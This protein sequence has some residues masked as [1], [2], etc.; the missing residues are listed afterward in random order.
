MKSFRPEEMVLSKMEPNIHRASDELTGPSPWKIEAS[1]LVELVL[2]PGGDL[3]MRLRRYQDHQPTERAR[4]SYKRIIGSKSLLG[5]LSFVSMSWLPSEMLLYSLQKWSVAIHPE[6]MSAFR[7]S[8][9]KRPQKWPA[10]GCGQWLLGRC[11]QLTRTML[12]VEL[13]VEM[14]ERRHDVARTPQCSLSFLPAGVAARP[15]GTWPK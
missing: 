4:L 7:R 11:Q 8:F 1:V 12:V 14:N 10:R 9:S 3:R 5:R 15:F 2:S 6:D 13:Q